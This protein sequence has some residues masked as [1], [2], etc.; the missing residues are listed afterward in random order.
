MT[1]DAITHTNV[2]LRDDLDS[3]VTC[4]SDLPSILELVLFVGEIHAGSTRCPLPLQHDAKICHV[5]SATSW[6]H[7]GRASAEI[8]PSLKPIRDPRLKDETG[9]SLERR[10][11]SL[12]SLAVAVEGRRT[13]FFAKRDR[14]AGGETP[15]P[16]LL[17]GTIGVLGNVYPACKIGSIRQSSTKCVGGE[18]R[19][20]KKGA[21]Y[22]PD[23][24]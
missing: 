20:D 14:H 10:K 3:S 16:S 17:R 9:I 23:G 15:T 1:S 24:A 7:G 8:N 18:E 11:P 6:S 2:V 4:L 21:H 12:I 19:G 5:A 22:V 13:R